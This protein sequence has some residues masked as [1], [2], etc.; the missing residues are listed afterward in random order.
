[1]N[2][3]ATSTLNGLKAT[4]LK[5]VS[6]DMYILILICMILSCFFFVEI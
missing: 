3:R 5:H 1:M 4:K 6:G 2:E